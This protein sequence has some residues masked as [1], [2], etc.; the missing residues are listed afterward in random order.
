MTDTP[1]TILV[2]AEGAFAASDFDHANLRSIMRAA[3]A[4]PA[5]IHY[6]Y[7]SREALARAVLNR[8]LG[9]SQARRLE[10]SYGHASPR[11]DLHKPVEKSFTPV[12]QRF[13]PYFLAAQ[14]DLPPKPSCGAIRWVV[15]GTLGALLSEQAIDADNLESELANS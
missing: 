6:R 1:S 14:P 10:P 15:F 7:G 5:S 9:P 4:T 11:H 2:A 8:T 13:A 12:A 3:N